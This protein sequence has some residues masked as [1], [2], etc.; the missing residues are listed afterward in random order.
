[1]IEAP[2]LRSVLGP[3]TGVLVAAIV[4][5]PSASYAAVLPHDSH[6][7]H[8]HHHHRHQHRHHHQHQHGHPRHQH[9]HGA[10]ARRPA[11]HPSPAPSWPAGLAGSLAG[12]GREH[13]G[14]PA[15]AADFGSPAPSARPAASAAQSAQATQNEAQ[16]PE[17]AQIPGPLV[18]PAGQRT[19]RSPAPRGTPSRPQAAAAP[20]RTMRVLPFGLGLALVGLGMAVIGLGMRRR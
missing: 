6:G 11:A 1:M 18:P 3:M 13:P 7:H 4:I 8:Q 14:R 5:L 10:H 17:Q 19:R 9:R 15:D 12:E 20:R 16:Q 2:R